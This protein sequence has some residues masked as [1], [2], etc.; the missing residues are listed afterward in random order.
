MRIIL[1]SIAFLFLAFSAQSQV[2][3]SAGVWYFL[4]VD[5][6]TARPAVLPNGTE[7]AYVVGTKTVYYWNRNTSTWTAYGSTFNR[8]SIYFDASIVGSG[9]VGDPWRVD[10]TLF[11]TIQAVGDSIMAN[12]QT[13]S[14]ANPLL[15]IS[16]G[17]NVD[18]SPL[19]TGYV[20]GSGTNNRIPKWS[21]T[22]NLTDSN[23]QDDGT[24]VSILSSKPFMLGQW[25]TAGRPTGVLGYTGFNSSNNYPEFY[26]G[27][28]W[29]EI[30]TPW[31]R[32]SAYT[33]YGT[34]LA[35]TRWDVQISGTQVMGIGIIKDSDYY[36]MEVGE[37]ATK[38]GGF[39]WRNALERVDFTTF[40]N[41]YPIAFG[42]N[43]M[44]M[45][46]DGK[47]GFGTAS[48]GYNV[49][50]N[51]NQTVPT[52]ARAYN[53]NT[54]ANVNAGFLSQVES[55]ASA[56]GVTAKGGASRSAYKILS[57]ND[58]FLYN[59]TVSGNIS[60]LN[61]F[62]SGN[63][64][65][66]AG[67]SSSSQ[68]TLLANGNFLLGT[69]TDVSR[70]LHIS[71]EAR[72]TDLTTDTPTRIVGADADGD[73]G[74]IKLGA[75]LTLSNDTIKATG[76][77][78]SIYNNL[79]LGNVS[80]NA[81]SNE[82]NISNI[83]VLTLGGTDWEIYSDDF[84][85]DIYNPEYSEIVAG[86]GAK[87]TLD[88]TTQLVGITGTIKAVQ[89]G[90]GTKEAADLSKT[91]SNFIAGWATDGTV[92][93]LERKRDTTIFLTADTDYDFGAAVTTAQIA[94]RYNRIIIH[95]T[96]TSGVGADKTT[97]LHTP[98]A[99]LMQCEILIRGTDNTGTY[100]NE[101]AFGT[102]NA[103]SSDGTDVSG[104]TLAQ[105]QG[106]HVRVVYNG[107]A[108]KYIYY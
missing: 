100:D 19:L 96:L 69:T 108:Y 32:G 75:G 38:T 56:I 68:A 26:N 71:G 106:L 73:L 85:T 18:L 49:D 93:D 21:A 63:I 33:Y 92:L 9:T 53:P 45:A 81:N 20:T 95:M 64:R 80:I 16:D 57:A 91:Q 3:K 12:K 66:A 46:N 25:T 107:S 102:N 88:N 67:G 2:L 62:A 77:G 105:G 74:A 83:S 61:D 89:Y 76:G 90:L 13:L 65:F 31:Q 35:N 104:Y 59:G 39:Y 4:D 6:M 22:T 24:A 34:D 47:V 51:V 28:A 29:D 30:F 94:S 72:I 97:T 15:G 55:N 99:N 10:S 8:D 36:G 5:S 54:G 27:S 101:I 87:V 86:T 42:N 70:R 40:G 11:A 79:P 17:N 7:L 103:I 78:N 44:Y 14:F 43:W 60:I 48:P 84:E 23:V 52:Y 82:L 98:D 58:Y 37:S 1:L 50:I 41:T